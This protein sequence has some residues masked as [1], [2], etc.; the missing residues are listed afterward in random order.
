MSYQEESGRAG[1]IGAP[2]DEG[3][4]NGCFDGDSVAPN[5]P[6]SAPSFEFRPEELGQFRGT[7]YELIPLNAPAALDA[8][9][10][11]I[12]KAPLKGWRTSPHL[13]VDEAA[14]HM[15]EGHNI[16]V[17]LRLCDLVVDVDPRN[18]EVGDDPVA[19]LQRDLGFR[20]DDFPKVATGSGGLHFYMLMPDG[21]P[22][23]DTIAIYGGIEFKAHGRQVV[24]PGSAHP[25]TGRPYAWDDDFLGVPLASVRHAPKALI[26]LIRRPERQLSSEAG[27]YC[28]DELAAMLEGLDPCAF[29]EHSR[30]LSLMMACHHATAGDGREEFLAWSAGDP[31]YRDRSVENG[32]RWDSLHADC[33]GVR[34]TAA[35]LRKELIDAGRQDLIPRVAAEDDFPDDLANVE[36]APKEG[37]GDPI[38]Q[39][40]AGMNEKFC[41]VLEGG[42]F[43]VYMRDLDDL[44]DPPRPVLTRLSRAAFRNYHE[45]ELVTLPDKRQPVSVADLWLKHP[46]MRKHPGIVLDPDGREQDK[47]N[48]WQGWAV[49]PMPGDWSLMRELIENVLCA[50]NR[51]HAEYVL[52]WIAFMVQKPGVQPQTAI[53]FRGNEGTGKS[54]LGRML[55]RLAGRHGIT[56]SSPKQL[57]G[58]FNAHLRNAVFVFADEALWPGNKENE[59]TLKQLVT[60]PVISFEPKGKDV[61][62]GRNLVHLMLASNEE[63]VVPAGKDARRFAVFDVS[64]ARRNDHGFFDRLNRQ[65]DEGGLAAMLHDLLAMDLAGWHPARNV[66]QTRALADQKLHSL[67]PASKFWMEVLE[68]GSVGLIEEAEW[69]AGPITLKDERQRLIEEYDTF[70]KRNRVFAAK[71]TNKALTAAG[72]AL[73]LEAVKLDRNNGRGW[74]LPPLAEARALFERRIG[75]SGVFG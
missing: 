6:P 64:D 74:V 48:L 33:V 68:R 71:A 46:K 40:V 53:A 63:W 50:G 2:A 43:H 69:L 1:E 52:R 51:E 59:G 34:V 58:N 25:A 26:D 17:R 75:A 36:V 38:T 15:R 7:G 14:A 3:L 8:R 27:E 4:E 61:V 9:G 54:T 35:T 31:A 41:A 55:M 24:A 65:M 32:R 62:L 20:L 57:A 72:K 12:G 19:R 47:L 70:L 29:A 56:V 44:Y 66:P 39:I 11:S 73:G 13:T 16:G 28:A 21:M 67:D 10:R 60:E 45:N 42:D 22:V 18:F 23:R 37:E 30:W 5:T 49:T